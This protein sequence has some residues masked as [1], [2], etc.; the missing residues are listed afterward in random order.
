[1]NIALYGA[2][3][4]GRVVLDILRHNKKD[5]VV[6][7]IDDNPS[8]AGKD[9]QGIRIITCAEMVALAKQKKLD[10]VALAVGDN[11]ARENVFGKCK[12]ME[13]KVITAI[14]PT[15]IVAKDAGIG[16]GCVICAGAIICTNARLGK[17]VIVNTGAT[18]DHD[19]RINDFV[20]ISPGV[21]VGGTVAIGARSWI[22]I[23]SAVNN[24]LTI[25][26][27]VIVGSGSS[28]IRNIPDRVMAA[29]TPA[30]I[31]KLPTPQLTQERSVRMARPFIDQ[32][33]INGVAEVLKSGTL[34]L[35]PRAEE[36]ELKFAKFIGTK[37][38]VAVANGTCGLHLLVRLLNLKEGDE[39]ITSPFSFISSANCLL[40]ERLKP[41]FVDI[42][43]TTLNIDTKKIGAAITR[44][45]RAILPVH[46]FGLSCDM[47]EINRIATRHRLRVIE[48]ACEA[49]AAEHDGK[50]VGTSGNP[51]VFA[52]YANK[53][54]TTGEG[55]MITTDSREE[56]ALLKS[57]RN[58]GRPASM[59][60]LEHDK[61]GYNY[62]LNEMSCSLGITQLEKLEW[63]LS[64]KNKLAQLYAN[65]IAKITGVR[66]LPDLSLQGYARSWFVYVVLLDQGIDRN[67]VMAQL[68]ESGIQARQY[69]PAIHLQK[70]YRERFGY[71]E[72]DCPVCEQVSSQ[73][74]ALPFF[75]GLRKEEVRRVVDTLAAAIKEQNTQTFKK[76]P[77]LSARQ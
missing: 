7:I 5:K 77:G 4:H 27:D 51:A 38:A 14:H 30:T 3:G 66:P 57:L 68:K 33:D 9:F 25:G 50:K 74:L 75:I 19:C 26:E 76:K 59:D 37:H 53:Q 58:Q 32:N 21:H 28:V 2:S 65:C 64:E 11:T 70:L 15:A 20:H 39:V 61:I 8:F 1:M 34:S 69:F 71:K 62:R 56:Y 29:G 54:M 10:A 60:W 52:F 67:K 73:T 47:D 23:G 6:A 40:S 42:D 41:V 35:G 12:T 16:E 49:V 63:M 46:I 24:D 72:G 36:F 13:I 45:T 48:D 18:V 55:G 22:G 17:G 31:K 44:K 43:R